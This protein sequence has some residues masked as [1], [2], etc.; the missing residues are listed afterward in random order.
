[1][2]VDGPEGA[3]VD[4]GPFARTALYCYP[5]DWAAELTDERCEHGVA[6]NCEQCEWE[7]SVADDQ[8]AD[9]DWS[10]P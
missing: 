8:A 4:V 2:T 9:E 7:Q 3:E 1:V 6:G 5:M 10:E